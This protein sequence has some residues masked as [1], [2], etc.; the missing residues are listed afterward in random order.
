M[1]QQDKRRRSAPHSTVEQVSLCVCPSSVHHLVFSQ[2]CVWAQLLVR[3]V[4]GVISGAGLFLGVS[5]SLPL[6]FD[7]RLA[8][9]SVFVGVCVVCGALSSSFR[10]SVLLMFPSMLGSRGRA[11][12][13]VFILSVLYTGP[14]SNMERNVRAAALSLS[15]NLDLQVHH[16]RLLWRD[17][18]S[19]YTHILQELQDDK[20]EFESD[21][22]NVSR[23]FQIIRDE[24]VAQYGYNQ[25]GNSSQERFTTQTMMQCDR[26]VTEGV[27]RCSDWFRGKWEECMEVIAVP[28][29][30][31]V[32]CVPMTFHFLCDVMRV[33]TP[34]CR[35]HVPVEGNFGQLY[36]ELD[37]SVEMLSREFST[38]LVVQ[39]Q[40]QRSVLSGPVMDQEFTQTVRGSLQKLNAVMKEVLDVLQLLL[41]FTFITIFTRAFSYV[42]YYRKD[43]R[44]DNVYVTKYFRLIDARRKK[45]GKRC[46]LPLTR[47]GKKKLIE[48]RS[49]RIHPDE[50]K[51]VVSGVLQ[52]LSVSLLGVVLLIIDFSLVHTLDI[53]SR[54]TISQF[55]VTSIRKVDI[56]VGGDS[57]MARLLRKTVSAFNSS[58]ILHIQTDNQA[59]V[60]PPST[61][62]ADVYVYCVCCVLLV[63]LFTLLQV[64]TNRLRRVIAAFYHP[65]REKKRVLFLYN[66]QLQRHMSSVDS[67]HRTRT[68]FHSLTTWGC[69]RCRHDRREAESDSETHYDPS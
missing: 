69:R 53:V 57:M 16:S 38:E 65:Q 48:P 67:G 24:V 39:E 49:L 29:I 3:C 25:T 21:A 58:S 61:L 20:A 55:N 30:N 18:V 10:C 45:A 2:E 32:F 41:S 54:H 19:P 42:R 13:F 59:C 68:V 63:A 27:N 33:M 22:V 44:F 1:T 12:L 64:Y 36:D 46:V 52:L 28:V 8:V 66:L 34:W 50:F 40:Q 23:R 4:F 7:L 43:I 62:S 37:V 6:T 56:K 35:E 15:C 60:S 9:G 5:H 47:S 14:V 17:A 51:E 31:H 11:Y 26:V